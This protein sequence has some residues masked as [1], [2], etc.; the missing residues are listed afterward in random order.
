[1]SF[2]YPDNVKLMG[3]SLFKMKLETSSSVE[4]NMY[5]L[6]SLH[7]VVQVFKEEI[8]KGNNADLALLSILA[9]YVE[10]FF[11]TSRVIDSN[12]ISSLPKKSN[13]KS[14]GNPK[15]KNES[16]DEL[17]VELKPALTKDQLEAM[18]IKFTSMVRGYCD[19]SL[20]PDKNDDKNANTAAVIRRVS[21]IIWNTLNEDKN[22]DRS[23]SSN[24]YRKKI[25]LTFFFI[26]T[27]VVKSSFG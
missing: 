11:T 17:N 10:D 1:M 19:L 25:V 20:I 12:K 16:V 2:R 21:D 5:P 8:K 18:H 13:D 4:A 14:R 22:K 6:D 7:K 24:N 3:G 9:G 27:Q 15:K 23:H 26:Y